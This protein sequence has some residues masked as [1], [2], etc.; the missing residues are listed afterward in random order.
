MKVSA[1]ISMLPLGTELSLSPYIAACERILREADLTVS[2]HSQGTNVEG[3]YDEVF[4]AMKR[5]IEKVHEMGCVRLSVLVKLGSRTDKDIDGD[6][7][8]RS[9]EEKLG[10]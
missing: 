5:C 7:M 9:V 6:A 8:V 2:L 4:G 1:M 10:Y 3:E